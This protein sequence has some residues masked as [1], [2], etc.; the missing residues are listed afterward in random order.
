MVT[1]VLLSIT[2][3]RILTVYAFDG[4]VWL[5]DLVVGALFVGAGLVAWSRRSRSERRV[6]RGGMT[7]SRQVVIVGLGAGRADGRHLLVAGAALAPG[8]RGRALLHQ[9][10]AG[11][12]LMLTTEV[13]NFPGFVEG[14]MGPELMQAFREQ[15]ARFGA[16]YITAKVS[17][18]DLSSRPFGL[19]V[20]DPDAEEPTY[21]AE[22]LIIATGAQSLM[23][24]LPER[25]AAPRLRGV[26]L[27]HLR[28]IL[29]PGEGD[30]R[31]RRGRLGHGRGPLPDP[32][33]RQGH[34]HPPPG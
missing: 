33:R 24:N 9:R 32:L 7:E 12:Q 34:H 19:W 8:H 2:L 23:L 5:S 20:G 31:R 10:P 28:R 13:E 18:V 3:I 27:R 26:H 21:A 30:R 17:R 6:R 4:R 16:E 1:V 14:I 11:G 15:A 29:L 22:T 25:G